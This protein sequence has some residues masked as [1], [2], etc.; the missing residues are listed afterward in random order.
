MS[1]TSTAA[2][3]G[4]STGAGVRPPSIRSRLANALL[5]WALAWGLAVGAAVWLAAAHEVDE[6]LDDTLQSSSELMALVVAETARNELPAPAIV[7]SPR[8]GSPVKRFAWQLTAADGSLLMRSARAPDVAWHKTPTAGF[9]EAAK[10]RIYGRPLGQDGRMLYTAQT[11]AE[12]GEARMEVA[13]DA[14]L[15]ALLVGLLGYVWLRARV[16]AEL[17]PLDSI[18]RRLAKWDFDSPEHGAVLGPA[19]RRE[20]EPVHGAIEALAARLSARLANEQAFAAHA[21]HSLRTPLAG[22]DAQLAMALREC[23]PGVRD[24]LQRVRG[25]TTRLQG[26]VAALLGLFRAGGTLQREEIEVDAMVARLPLPTLE[27][28]V[29]PGTRAMADPDLLAAVLLNLL[30][31]A[32]RHGARHAWLEPAADGG[33]V[34]RDDGPG[35]DATRRRHLQAALDAQ[36]YDRLGGLGLMLADRVARAHGGRLRL[37]ET[38]AGFTVHLDLGPA[39]VTVPGSIASGTNPVV[40]RSRP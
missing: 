37:V 14:T 28:E 20:L 27:V 9:S 18:S 36:A 8:E 5:A 15:A 32:Q 38:D 39:A 30:E 4:T 35:V 34:L 40:V 24:R 22:I 13:L 6:L 16:R 19:E 29:A 3:A 33:L 17:R 10:W 25:A 21:A 11:Q 7:V 12:R 26:I 31:N 1:A 2:G 23:P